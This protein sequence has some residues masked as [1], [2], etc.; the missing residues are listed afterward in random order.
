MKK[1]KKRTATVGQSSGHNPH[2]RFAR[3]TVGD[4]ETAADILRHYTEPLIAKYIDLD[5]LTPA[6]TQKFGKAFQELFKDIAF[7][8]HLIDR[9]QKSE[10]LIIKEHKSTIEPFVL[11]QLLVYLVLTW[12]KRWN[13]AGRPQSTKK[14]RLPLPILVV[15]YNGK[16]DWKGELDLKELIA[17]VPPE[18]EPIIPKV[19][20]FFVRLNR[21]DKNRLPGKPKTK[22]VVESMIRATDGTFVVGLESI[23]GHFRDSS[24]DDRIYELMEDI[25]HYCDSV[26][27]VTPDKVDKAITNVLK[28]Q[29]EDKLS[30][31]DKAV[32]KAF[33]KVAWEGGVAE[34]KADTV[35][36]ILRDRFRKVPK[37]IEKAVCKIT[38]P[39]A[40]QSWVA[41][42]ATCES[43]NE[44]AEAID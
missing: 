18:L 13:D 25:V 12:Y 34:G 2:D 8:S 23:L 1:S 28:G 6:P 11:L 40:L 42:A 26:E 19:K 20:V 39:V 22:A 9:K 4:P 17:F 10:V 5:G 16:E 36:A 29:G 21:F 3:K 14:F 37:G 15:L 7:V 38:D 30:Q 35:L 24:L 27:V 33:T 44:F 43:L 32:R 31:A 41:F